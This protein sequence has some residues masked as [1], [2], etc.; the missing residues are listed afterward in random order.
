VWIAGAACAVVLSLLA[1]SSGSAEPGASPSAAASVVT[2]PSAAPAAPMGPPSQG[3][4]ARVEPALIAQVR[5]TVDENNRAATADRRAAEADGW[6]MVD[7]PPPDERLTRLD[8]ALLGAREADLR[9]QIASTTA[10]P[11]EV[12]NLAE[13]A[14]RASDDQ[15]RVLAV[16]A[17]GRVGP[18]GQD[19]LLALLDSLPQDDRA[20]REVIPLLRPASIDSP[21]AAALAARLDSGRLSEVE[22]KQAAFTL[23]LLSLRDGRPLPAPV[24]D[25]LSAGSRALLA[26]MDRLARN[27][28][29]TAATESP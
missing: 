6:K 26:A 19:Q 16:E 27:A 21:L 11:S 28:S 14:R 4:P 9:T 5:R 24:F 2:A 18:E 17:L 1:F 13:I 3:A 7:V 12:D 10:S 20:R 23:A 15:T 22:R 8:P 29:S 25:A